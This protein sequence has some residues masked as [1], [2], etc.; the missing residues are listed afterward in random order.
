LKG[1]WDEAAAALGLQDFSPANQDRAAWWLAQRDYRTRTGR[2]LMA[3]LKSGDPAVRSG[4]GPALSRTWTSLP[5]GIEEGTSQS[6]FLSRLATATAQYQGGAPAGNLAA[7]VAEGAARSLAPTGDEV[8]RALRGK[9]ELEIT[10][11]LPP[12]MSA[13]VRSSSGNVR[14]SGPLIENTGMTLVAP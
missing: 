1:T 12:G 9:L 2:D 14:A 7:P 6:R 11:R 4:I 8:S 3:D 5:G 10:G 13:Q